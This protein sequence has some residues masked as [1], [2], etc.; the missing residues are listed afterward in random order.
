MADSFFN[1]GMADKGNREYRDSA[2]YD[3]HIDNALA[4]NEKIRTLPDVYYFSVPCSFSERQA[5]GTYI[6][7]K[8]MEELYARRSYQMGAYSGIS[9]GGHPI[10]EKW[11][12]NDGLVNTISAMAPLK[13]PAKKFERDD[14]PKGI[15]NVFETYHGDHMALQGGLMHKHDIRSFYTDLLKMITE[16]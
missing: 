6:P 14:I 5:D 12:D 4:M 9:R 10:D 1:L 7:E 11:R 13:A 16:L 3:M 15:W 2:A 8:G